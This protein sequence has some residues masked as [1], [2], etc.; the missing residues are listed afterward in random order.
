VPLNFLHTRRFIITFKEEE[1]SPYATSI[2]MSA[3]NDMPK[4][5]ESILCGKIN[6]F[7]L[8]REMCLYNTHKIARADGYHSTREREKERKKCI[9]NILKVSLALL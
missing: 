5:V 2:S 1:A 9:C 8:P 3:L 6:A 4:R 7:F